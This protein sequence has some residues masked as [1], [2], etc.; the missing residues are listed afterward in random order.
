[1]TNVMCYVA[2]W[3]GVVVS[4]LASINEVNLHRARLV[5]RWATVSGFSSRCWT[6]ISVWTSHPRPTQLSIPP[7][8]V[9]EYQL[10]LG[11][12]R[13]VS[14]ILLADERGVCR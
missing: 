6:L 3:S 4:M 2:W 5:L 12:Q 9:N 14:F 8:L 11:R 10:Q 7:G 1:M 13:Q